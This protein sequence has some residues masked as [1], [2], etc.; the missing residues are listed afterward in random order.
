MK[1]LEN[2]IESI[3][4]F[5]AKRS[6]SGKKEMTFWKAVQNRHFRILNWYAETGGDLNVRNHRG[7][8]ALFD[9]AT[10]GD[11]ELT[12]ELLKLGANPNALS[13]REHMPDESPLRG[14]LYTYVRC[15]Y[16]RLRDVHAKITAEL[17]RSGADLSI[18]DGATNG[19]HPIFDAIEHGHTETVQEML[20]R[21]VDPNI[22]DS[23][24]RTPL[25][26]ATAKGNSGMVKTLLEYKANPNLADKDYEKTPLH[27]AAFEGYLDI[28][29]LLLNAGADTTIRDYKNRPPLK[30]AWAGEAQVNRRE[31]RGRNVGCDW[32][33]LE[34]RHERLQEI[35]KLLGYD[36]LEELRKELE[37]P[38]DNE[39]A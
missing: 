25:W 12:R 14:I 29:Q 26:H 32:V 19:I 30:S 20:I 35:M 24:C 6:S 8:T 37:I 2:L 36:E 11:L 23:C 28:F 9:A 21:G 27:L 38:G 18:V 22:S 5:F 33:A 13:S 7:H 39:K 15:S 17:V 34:Q 3:I 31:F 10:K 1:W 16:G 4:L